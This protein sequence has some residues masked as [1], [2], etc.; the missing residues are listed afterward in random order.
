MSTML[1]AI[2][3]SF[4]I[5]TTIPPNHGHHY[6]SVSAHVHIQ[7]IPERYPHTHPSYV[8]PRRVYH[9]NPHIYLPPHT[10]FPY[11]YHPLPGARPRY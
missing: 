3:L 1:A 6:P 2:A 7:T 5:A 11:E 4:G 8:D 10:Q 9:P